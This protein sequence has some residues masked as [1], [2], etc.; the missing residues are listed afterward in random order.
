MEIIGDLMSVAYIFDIDGTLTPSRSQID[1]KFKDWFLNFQ[2]NNDVYLVT[3]SDYAKTVEQVGIDICNASLILFNCCGN[4]ARVGD[5]LLYRNEWAGTPELIEELNNQLQKSKF[6]IRT[7][8]HIEMR[9]GLINFSVVGRGATKDQ[10]REYVEFDIP[11]RERQLIAE[12]LSRQFPEIEFTI[13]GE[14]GIDIY[15]LGKDKS[16]VLDWIKADVTRFFGDMIVPGGN[17]WGIAQKSSESYT[18]TDWK[19]TKKLLEEIIM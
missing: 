10:R 13:A 14:T 15:P 19:H 11:N 9:T 3:G 1:P 17:D 4:E 7:G 8:Q 5:T 6:P 2:K 12:H 16:Q 18:V